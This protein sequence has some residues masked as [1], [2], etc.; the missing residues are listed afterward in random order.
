MGVLWYMTGMVGVWA[1]EASQARERSF[2]YVVRSW[3]AGTVEQ[4]SH[5]AMFAGSSAQ[6]GMTGGGLVWSGGAQRD[7]SAIAQ[8]IANSR[9]EQLS[10][11]GARGSELCAR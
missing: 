10:R 3:I 4:R 5:Y 7:R 1:G 8:N 6:R 9:L 11:A 2:T